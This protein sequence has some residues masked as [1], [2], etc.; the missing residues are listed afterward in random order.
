MV[1]D[2]VYTVIHPANLDTSTV[3]QME[4]LIKVQDKYAGEIR[5]PN[6]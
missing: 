5:C 6:T 2:Q 3:S 1:P 4:D